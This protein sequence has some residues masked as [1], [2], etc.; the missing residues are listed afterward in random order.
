MRPDEHQL[1]RLGYL[2]PK[3]RSLVRCEQYLEKN[4][5]TEHVADIST[6]A[7][8]WHPENGLVIENRGG[9][10]CGTS[11]K[12][13]P[14]ILRTD[15]A[16]DTSAVKGVH[17]RLKANS[18]GGA[19]TCVYFI[20]DTDTVWTESK[21]VHVFIKGDVMT[22]VYYDM[23]SLPTWTGT[24]TG[25]RLDPTDI[26]GSFEIEAIELTTD[27]TSPILTVNGKEHPCSVLPQVTEKGVFIPFEQNRPYAD[28]KFYHEWYRDEQ[29]LYLLHGN[30][31][32]YFTV[33]KD[34]VLVNGKKHKLPAPLALCDA[35]PMLSLDVLCEICGFSYT[36]DGRYIRVVTA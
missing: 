28:M 29:T 25:L 7:A 18:G 21:G 8:D 33:G 5:P 4:K 30:D 16:I 17:I 6:D 36:K 11:D 27:T 22:D 14:Q 9:K 10:L 24:V 13:D 20:T 2:Y 1:D 35:L 32:M 26:A 3:G 34:Y 23:A 15:L 31:A 19:N 12:F